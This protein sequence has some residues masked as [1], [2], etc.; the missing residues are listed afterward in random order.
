M[1]LTGVELGAWGRDLAPALTLYDLIAGVL[2]DSSLRRL[3]LSSI[4][5]WDFKPRILELWQDVRL[6]RHL[7]IPLQAATITSC[8]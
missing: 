4:E 8:M 2:D 5:P 6:C 3:R 1:V 7:H